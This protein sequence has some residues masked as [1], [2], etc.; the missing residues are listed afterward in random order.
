[1]PS[2][3]AKAAVQRQKGVDRLPLRLNH[4]SQLMGNVPEDTHHA[5]AVALTLGSYILCEPVEVCCHRVEQGLH[6]VL[7]I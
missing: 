4:D 5:Q 3:T 2:S 6:M 1:M 7:E